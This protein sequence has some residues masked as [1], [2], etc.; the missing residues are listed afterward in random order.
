[1]PTRR[2]RTRCRKRRMVPQHR[3]TTVISPGC[4]T[5]V[6][7]PEPQEQQGF[8]ELGSVC[9]ATQPAHQRTADTQRHGN[10]PHVL[11]WSYA[12]RRF[13]S[14]WDQD[15]ERR[16]H[17]RAAN[18]QQCLGNSPPIAEVINTDDNPSGAQFSR[19]TDSSADR[20]RRFTVRIRQPGVHRE[21][22]GFGTETNPAQTQRPGASGSDPAARVCFS[23]SVQKIASSRIRHPT[24]RIRIHEDGAEQTERHTHTQMMMY[25]PPLPGRALSV[26]THRGTQ[27]WVWW[28]LPPTS[29]QVVYLV[30]TQ[31]GE[32]EQM[33]ETVIVTECLPLASPSFTSWFM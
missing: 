17:H 6:T 3:T 33:E 29:D 25:F 32:Q 9:A 15:E 8:A 26:D 1:M 11:H 20:A 22:T 12:S 18:Q 19:T 23:T 13:I 14:R 27:N 16:H 24:R 2:P 4:R 28:L 30:I 21:Q 7:L 31:H 5:S 10:Q